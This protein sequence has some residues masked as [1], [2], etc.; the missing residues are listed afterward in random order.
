MTIRPAS[1]DDAATIADLNCRLA[2][3]SESLTLD[4]ARVLAGVVRALEDGSRAR[5]WLAIV[6]GRVVGQLMQTWEW[7]DWRNGMFWWIQSVYVLP[8]YRRQGVFRRLHQHLRDLAIA[9]PDVV[10]LRLYV[11]HANQA[12]KATYARL[13]MSTT[14][15]EVLEETFGLDRS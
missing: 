8:D 12:A 9:D 13:G 3:E 1:L 10:G 14:G 6:D 15:Y 11:E 7:S 4:P 2:W 5:Y